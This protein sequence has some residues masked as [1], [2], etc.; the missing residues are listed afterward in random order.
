MDRMTV[1]ADFRKRDYGRSSELRTLHMALGTDVG[2]STVEIPPNACNRV[3]GLLDTGPPSLPGYFWQAVRQRKLFTHETLI[4]LR[5]RF[6]RQL[7]LQVHTLAPLEPMPAAQLADTLDHY[8]EQIAQLQPMHLR[9]FPVYLL[10]LADRCLD[11]G[12]A[13][14]GLKA[15]GPYGGLA[16]P[17]MMDRMMTVV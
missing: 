2:V 1:V 16:S 17:V 11:R 15:V 5:G 14:V 3:C 13:P 12:A 7:V 8:L 9:G 10:W 6:E 4:E